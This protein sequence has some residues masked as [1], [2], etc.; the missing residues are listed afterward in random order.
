[1]LLATTEKQTSWSETSFLALPR[2][3]FMHRKDC[4]PFKWNI[5][6]TWS[7]RCNH[8]YCFPFFM[9]KIIEILRWVFFC[10][11]E[12]VQFQVL[13]RGKILF[14]CIIADVS[15][16]LKWF[17]TE[18]QTKI[19]A[20][21]SGN[22]KDMAI[23]YHF[24]FTASDLLLTL[25]SFFQNASVILTFISTGDEYQEIHSYRFSQCN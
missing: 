5:Q 24:P 23:K 3:A 15:Y 14:Y 12:A 18:I 4:T 20:L 25:Y 11:K 8:C 10:V 9:F 22:R 13:L 1:M 2:M 17:N 7:K 21:K 19:K 6:H 16:P